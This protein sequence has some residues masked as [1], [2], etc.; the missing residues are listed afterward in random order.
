MAKKRN[1]PKLDTVPTTQYNQALKAL[2]RKTK[3]IR[4]MSLTND[5]LYSQSLEIG[6]STDKLEL[7]NE[8][9]YFYI[10]VDRARS[11][12][13]SGDIVQNV[14]DQP[15]LDATKEW[16]NVTTTADDEHEWVAKY[17]M[18]RLEQLKAKEVG[19][20]YLRMRRLYSYGAF[21]LYHI[22][23]RRN[24]IDTEPVQLDNIHKIEGITAIGDYEFELIFNYEDLRSPSY[25]ELDYLSFGG[26][27]YHKS[28]FN[29]SNIKYFPRERI[30]VSMLHRVLVP[31]RGIMVCGWSIAS[32]MLETQFKVWK[33]KDFELNNDG[34][35]A[36]QMM[37]QT[38]Q[39]QKA[40]YM[41]IEDDFQKHQYQAAGVE[42]GE[43]VLYN[44][45][46]AASGMPQ[47][48]IKGQSQGTLTSADVD[49]KRY[50]DGVKATEQPLLESVLNRL[51]TYI[52]WEKEGLIY[53]KL[54]GDIKNLQFKVHFNPMYQ[55]DPKEQE[56]FVAMKQERLMR[57]LEK[58]LVT[59]KYI[60]A[61]I[62]PDMQKHEEQEQ[63]SEENKGK[64]YQPNPY[65]A[66]ANEMFY[67]NAIRGNNAVRW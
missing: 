27:F 12:Y 54:K 60:Q 14:I 42:E 65:S 40:I 49:E 53:K 13:A 7:L 3:A 55:E 16:I 30:G 38:L 21:V 23:E 10:S 2:E 35:N 59:K 63:E 18:D 17:I 20:N 22:D 66:M 31:V 37:N 64:G 24:V 61:E 33:F 28:R 6:T 34:F 48:K 4:Q 32:M 46:S 39:S 36:G 43:R 44:Y 67:Q 41:G 57:A 5:H 11:I 8:F 15:A 25:N 50:Y 47:S 52:I 9:N 62:Y 26:S 56:Q 51:I 58:G 45:L 19:T 1:K 29:W